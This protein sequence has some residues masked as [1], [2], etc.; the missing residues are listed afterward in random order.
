M[1]RSSMCSITFGDGGHAAAAGLEDGVDGHCGRQRSAAGRARRCRGSASGAASAPSMVAYEAFV[2]VQAGLPSGEVEHRESR[3]LLWRREGAC[4]QFEE[5]DADDETHALV[6]VDERVVADDGV[7]VEGGQADDIGG[8]AVRMVLWMTR[9]CRRKQAR[10]AH[11]RRAAVERQQPIVDREHVALDDPDWCRHFDRARSVSRYRAAMSSTWRILR[12]KSGSYGVRWYPPSGRLVRW[13]V[14]P[15]AVW[16]AC[17]TSLGSTTP[18]ELPIFR[19]LS[20]IV[21]DL[22]AMLAHVWQRAW[23]ARRRC[24]S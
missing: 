6:P 4:V 12:S 9:Q 11:A 22:R 21:V 3:E 7:R 24:Q 23:G 14:P 20:W 1:R 15:S 19:T 5:Q 16:S 2:P 10:I 17:T 18:S 8:I 13:S